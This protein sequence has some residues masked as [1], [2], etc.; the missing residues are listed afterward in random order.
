MASVDGES[1][2]GL[3]AGDVVLSIGARA[4]DP[5]SRFHRILGSY[6][7][8][9]DVALHLRRNGQEVTVKARRHD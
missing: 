6:G 9:E 3:E 2:L 5:L 8:D 4:V 1:G 7:E